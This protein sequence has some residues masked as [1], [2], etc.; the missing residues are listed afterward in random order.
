MDRLTERLH[1]WA[2]SAP[3]VI[4]DPGA[5]RIG[6]E[7]ERRNRR[8]LGAAVVTAVAV[9]AVA[10]G[11]AAGGDGAPRLAPARPAPTPAW[12][13]LPGSVFVADPLMSDPEWA[14]LLGHLP[15]ERTVRAPA[16]PHPLDCIT[17]PFTL[18]ASEAH[19]AAYVQPDRW[20]EIPT[21]P[22][23]GRM[24]E[25]VL[26]FADTKAAAGALNGL[27]QEYVTCRTRP[28]PGF[29]IT[30][31]T[32][33]DWLMKQEYP[34]VEQQF[35][36]EIGKQRTTSNSSAAFKGYDLTVARAGRLVVVWESMNGWADRPQNT[37]G[38]L[39]NEAIKGAEPN[40]L[41]ALEPDED[42]YVAAI[43][44]LD[45]ATG[46]ASW[47]AGVLDHA[48]GVCKVLALGEPQ[49][50]LRQANLDPHKAVSIVNAAQAHLCQPEV[51]GG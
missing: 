50:A 49:E 20:R 48:W 17:D 35:N 2:D 10:V 7:R 23:A 47:R 28:D 34:L 5:V 18:G 31:S 3:V 42:A 29:D 51:S 44:Q 26:W 25:Y 37:I 46:N 30:G 19:G 13:V 14:D 24:N 9:L 15:G 22:S 32:L 40:R 43:Q 1:E 33:D 38:Q 36:G 12:T 8:A 16:A 6:A 39:M 27:R 4:P 11:F 41:S 21:M 45:H